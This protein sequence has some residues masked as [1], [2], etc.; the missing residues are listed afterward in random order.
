MKEALGDREAAV[1]KR[2]K[3]G[4]KP[5]EDR[6]AA[7]TSEERRD[8]ALKWEIWRIAKL[9]CQRKKLTVPRHWMTAGL[10]R[11]R[12][13]GTSLPRGRVW[14]LAKRRLVQKEKRHSADD[15]ALVEKL[16]AVA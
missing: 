11:H 2:E 12:K 7:L 1:S 10:P 5:S 4:D 3:N 13:K 8:S 9:L 15:K 16:A 6:E 14:T